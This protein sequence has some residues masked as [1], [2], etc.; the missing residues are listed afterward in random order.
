MALAASAVGAALV[1][2]NE[3]A[4]NYVYVCVRTTGSTYTIP[5]GTKLNTC[6]GSRLQQYLYGIFQQSVAVSGSPPTVGHSTV[7]L[8]CLVAVISVGLGVV[9]VITSVGTMTVVSGLFAV[10]GLALCTA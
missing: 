5:K 2:P 6:N 9:A 1:R 3:A 4:G 10:A 8:A 7:T